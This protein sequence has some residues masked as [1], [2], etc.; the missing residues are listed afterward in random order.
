MFLKL[1]AGLLPRNHGRL[2]KTTSRTVT[3]PRTAERGTRGLLQ[4]VLQANK[5]SFKTYST[6][7]MY[8]EH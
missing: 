3:V 7:A 4:S 5:A 2:V 6:P 1:V 8:I